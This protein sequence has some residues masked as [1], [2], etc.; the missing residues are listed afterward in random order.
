MDINKKNEN[1]YDLTAVLF[2]P[3][4]ESPGTVESLVDFSEKV[5]ATWQHSPD[6]KKHEVALTNVPAGMEGNGHLGFLSLLIN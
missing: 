5:D 1:G 3:D 4:K 6:G 2:T